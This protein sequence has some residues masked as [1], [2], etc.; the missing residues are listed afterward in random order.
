M[1]KWAVEL[2]IRRE[3]GG[4]TTEI[5]SEVI[6]ARSTLIGRDVPYKVFKRGKAVTLAGVYGRWRSTSSRAAD[7]AGE[8]SHRGAGVRI[9][10]VLHRCRW[11]PTR[12]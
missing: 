8:G 6:F 7:A 10:I 2:L 4:K 3:S 12:T 1:A 9:T 11:G 5:T